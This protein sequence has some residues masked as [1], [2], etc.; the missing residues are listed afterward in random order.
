MVRHQASLEYIVFTGLFIVG[1][2][3]I[4]RVLY[5]SSGYG[6]AG[7]LLPTEEL[8]KS[9]E[10]VIGKIGSQT[11]LENGSYTYNVSQAFNTNKTIFGIRI[12]PNETE[13]IFGQ[14]ALNYSVTFLATG[15]IQK[16]G[17][18]LPGGSIQGTFGNDWFNLTHIS[19]SNGIV[20]Y[21]FYSSVME[22]YL[23]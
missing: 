3:F 5:G 22:D 10:Q 23:S 18:L 20:V 7:S 21:E 9:G 17:P 13:D 2:M 12:W 11:I 15:Q 4:F 14:K 16:V 19:Y 1:V 8:N 6:T